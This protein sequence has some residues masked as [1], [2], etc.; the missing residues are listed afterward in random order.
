M[1]EKNHKIPC[2]FT[3][4]TSLIHIFLDTFHF[5]S[6]TKKNKKM[7]K[8]VLFFPLLRVWQKNFRWRNNC[9]ARETDMHALVVG[10]SRV[11]V[12]QGEENH[13]IQ[14]K[15]GRFQMNCQAD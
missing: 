4:P 6:Q 10:L 15:L 12:L 5:L 8:T 13:L 2:Q 1:I 7:D 14:E 9:D 11:M 3:S